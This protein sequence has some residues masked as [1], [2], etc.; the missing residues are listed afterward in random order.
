[1]TGSKGSA[2]YR[3]STVEGIITQWKAE[4]IDNAILFEEQSNRVKA[5]DQNLK[6]NQKVGI[7]I[8]NMCR[9]F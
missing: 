6:D 4:L 9:L 2:D 8:L 5:W 3:L 1:M 7:C